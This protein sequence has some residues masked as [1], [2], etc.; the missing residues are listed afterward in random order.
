MD[1][2]SQGAHSSVVDVVGVQVVEYG[3]GLVEVVGQ[4]VRGKAL[5]GVLAF[6]PDV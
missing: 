1:L 6:L 5:V 4:L 3:E 2:E